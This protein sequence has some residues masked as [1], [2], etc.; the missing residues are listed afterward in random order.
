MHK[1]IQKTS[2][3]AFW[4]SYTQAFTG[5]FVLDM[6][7]DECHCVF[8]IRGPWVCKLWSHLNASVETWQHRTLPVQRLRALPQDERPEQ[9]TY[10]TQTQTGESHQCVYNRGRERGGWW[11]WMSV[12][13]EV[14]V[15]KMIVRWRE[16]RR[17]RRHNSRKVIFSQS[18]SRNCVSR[19][20]LA[21][22][23]QAV[24]RVGLSVLFLLSLLLLL[25]ILSLIAGP[26]PH[27]S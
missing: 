17:R 20:P 7:F 12:S 9:T 1:Q 6:T 4:W 19:S 5:R 24:S 2:N 22:S 21:P 18:V 11:W 8:F 14:A 15:N 10:Q 25:L 27:P 23:A 16:R 13:V 3:L 26:Q